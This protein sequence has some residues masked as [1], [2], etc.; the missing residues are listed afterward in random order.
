M[1]KA[2]AAMRVVIADD[3]KL[4]RSGLATLLGEAGIESVGEAGSADELLG[5]VAT[6]RPDAAIVDIKMPPSHSDEG[7]R[8][9][10][11]IRRSHPEVAVLVLSQYV[12]PS[13]AIRLLEESP[14]GLGYLL[15]DRVAHAASL[16]DALV[17]VT[18]GE[19]VVDPAIIS[20]LL[21]R[22]RHKSPLDALTAR[23]RE[24]LALMA[25]GRSNAAI[26]RLL[27]LSPKTVETHVSRVFSKLGLLEQA[28]DHR[29]VLAVLAFLR[30]GS[31]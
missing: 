24:V 11:D 31:P 13:Y 23:E 12:E 1:R 25:G 17:R 5:L 21:S 27:F 10:W 15:K 28:D 6:L 19:T 2:R 3:A 8:A 4:I 16:A 18:E 29:R 7:I 22:A 26:G 14:A 20:R 30:Q 9:A